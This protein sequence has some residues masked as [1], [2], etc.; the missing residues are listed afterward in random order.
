MGFRYIGAKTQILDEV[1]KKISEIVR[2][3]AVVAD[4][5]PTKEEK[6]A[7]AVSPEA[8]TWILLIIAAGM[9]AGMLVLQNRRTR[10]QVYE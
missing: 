3:S 8:D 1:L 9:T 2:P 10:R 6:V 4:I 7:T 5:D